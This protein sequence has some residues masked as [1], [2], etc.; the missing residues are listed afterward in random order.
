MVLI[1]KTLFDG[2][3]T[4]INMLEKLSENIETDIDAPI[5]LNDNE[6]EPA[7]MH[8]YLYKIFDISILNDEEKYIL[9][10]LSLLP[11]SFKTSAS[12]FIKTIKVTIQRGKK[13]NA[14]G[15]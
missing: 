9:M 11:S 2:R 15:R 10:N 13:N 12:S 1:A 14:T 4:P 8:D 5:M 6:K 3:V 7:L